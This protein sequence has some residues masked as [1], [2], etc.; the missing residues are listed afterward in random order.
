VRRPELDAGG[1]RVEQRFDLGGYLVRR[2]GEREAIEDRAGDQPAGPLVVPGA[3]QAL[4]GGQVHRVEAGRGIQRRDGREV[5]SHLRAGQ[6]PRGRPV[7]VDDGDSSAHQ[8]DIAAWA[9]RP[10]LA[11]RERR[12]R[13]GQQR[14][15][16]GAADLDLGGQLPGQGYPER[17]PRPQQQVDMPPDRPVGEAHAGF[18]LE[19]LAPVGILAALQQVPDDVGGLP[20]PADRPLLSDPDRVEPRTAGEPEI[21]AAAG[22]DIEHVQLIRYLGR[23]QEVGVQAGRPKPDAPRRSGDRD[24]RQQRRGIQ[25]VAV[26]RDGPEAELLDP[27]GQARVGREV[28]V[29]LQRDAQLAAGARGHVASA[30]A[31]VEWPVRSIRMISRS[32]GSGHAT[33]L[34]LSS[35]SPGLSRRCFAGSS[36]ST[37]AS[38]YTQKKRPGQVRSWLLCVSSNQ[39]PTRMPHTERP[40]IRSTTT[41]RS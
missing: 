12:E 37:A 8:A 41:R 22:D 4:H 23:M 25:Q 40:S 7:L 19:D 36:G 31:T 18:H 20:Q 26:D 28:L 13:G 24:Q 21:G 39:S 5:G 3:D 27:R 33:W 9:P 32:S 35:Q 2:P 14:R 15:V 11:A 1:P 29:R 16:R 30:R 17:P 38:A 6:A 34:S 10:G